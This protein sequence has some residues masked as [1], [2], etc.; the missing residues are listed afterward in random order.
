MAGHVRENAL[1]ERSE[2]KG[3]RRNVSEP[4][5]GVSVP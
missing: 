5:R 4:C 3:A 1:S 2:S